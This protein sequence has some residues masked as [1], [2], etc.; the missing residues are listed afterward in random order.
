MWELYIFLISTQILQ[1]FQKVRKMNYPIVESSLP[2]TLD[3]K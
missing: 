3:I 1:Q 2:A